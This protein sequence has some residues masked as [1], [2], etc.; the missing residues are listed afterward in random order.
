VNAFLLFLNI[1]TRGSSPWF[2]YVLGAMSIPLGL[3]AVLK[4]RRSRLQ[5]NLEQ[6]TATPSLPQPDELED[7][8]DLRRAIPGAVAPVDQIGHDLPDP[9]F[10]PLRRLHAGRTTFLAFAT[11][12]AT[13]SGYLFLIN[14]LTGGSFWSIIPAVSIA[15]PL[16]FWGILL[17]GRRQRLRRQLEV[18]QREHPAV[19]GSTVSLPQGAGSIGDHPSVRE[20]YEIRTKINSLAAE[21]SAGSD[22]LMARVDEM[23]GEIERMAR[24]E[25]GFDEALAIMSVDELERERDETAQQMA[26]ASP[27]IHGH[28]RESIDQIESQ[29]AGLRELDR[30]RELVTLRLRSGVNSL[31]QISLDLVRLRGD[32]TL[33]ELD[34]RIADQARELS[35]YLSDLQE[36]Y[37]ELSR[38]LGR[39]ESESG[40]L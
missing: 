31:R 14:A 32:Q 20:A 22:D 38:D 23:L 28:Y 1:V 39:P 34:D 13:T 7:P 5:A 8:E 2:L 3:H 11:I 19:A 37:A 26:Q 10:R 40:G 24:L 27:E 21:S 12:G 33:A 18:A 4:T 35:G 15:F 25:R 17:R 36:S 9:V 16:T 29:L 30:K 6:F